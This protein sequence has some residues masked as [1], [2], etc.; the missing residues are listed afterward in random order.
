M[1]ASQPLNVTAFIDRQPLSA[2]QVSIVVLCFL[3]VAGSWLLYPMS[4]CAGSP[5]HG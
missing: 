3:I 2:F 5:N 4:I 1:P